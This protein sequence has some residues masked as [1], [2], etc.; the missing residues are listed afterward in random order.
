MTTN[1]NYFKTSDLALATYLSQHFPLDCIEKLDNQRVMFCFNREPELDN[2]TE[3]YWHDQA[4]TSPIQYFNQL[5]WL[6]TRI[7]EG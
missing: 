3:A 1:Q 2:Y 7:R 5:R 6:K 4:V